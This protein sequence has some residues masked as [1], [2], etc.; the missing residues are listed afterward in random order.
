VR[1]IAFAAFIAGNFGL[2][3]V[4]EISSPLVGEAG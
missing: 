1:L 3:G 4:R 2:E